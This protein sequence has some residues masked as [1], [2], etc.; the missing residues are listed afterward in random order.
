MKIQTTSG[1]MVVTKNQLDW[2]GAIGQLRDMSNYPQALPC[3]DG[4][5]QEV[6]ELLK[7][8][9][10]GWSLPDSAPIEEPVVSRDPDP[11]EPVCQDKGEA[12]KLLEDIK[13]SLDYIVEFIEHVRL[14]P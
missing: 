12:I 1:L 10:A 14:H 13:E 8:M 4:P 11:D 6:V 2:L 5:E 9:P 3:F 7:T